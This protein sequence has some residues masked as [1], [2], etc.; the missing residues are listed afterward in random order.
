M[1]EVADLSDEP[2]PPY[3]DVRACIRKTTRRVSVAVSGETI[4]LYLC[5]NHFR[6]LREEIAASPR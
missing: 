3:C 4:D 6:D 2:D 1:I 5:P